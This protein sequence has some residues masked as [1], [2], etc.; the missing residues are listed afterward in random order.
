MN[1]EIDQLRLLSTRNG[2]R[3]TNKSLRGLL[4]IIKFINICIMIVMKERRERRVKFI[5][6]K[7]SWPQTFKFN[8][9]Y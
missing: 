2:K 7:K 1:S 8:E 6:M 9:K 4:Y 3:K 5:C